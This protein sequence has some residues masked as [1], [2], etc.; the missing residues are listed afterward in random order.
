MQVILFKYPSKYTSSNTECQNNLEPGQAVHY[1][2]P[3]IGPICLQNLSGHQLSLPQQ[4][5]KKN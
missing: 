5:D 2:T 1:L 4:D 3:D